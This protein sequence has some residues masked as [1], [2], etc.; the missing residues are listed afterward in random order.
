MAFFSAKDIP[1]KNSFTPTNLMTVLCEEQIFADKTIL[2]NGQPV[3]VIVANDFHLANYAATKV[4]INCYNKGDIK[5][6]R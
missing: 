5:L 3:G 4:K 6:I 1:G 2:Y